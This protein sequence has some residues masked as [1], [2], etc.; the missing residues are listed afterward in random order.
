MRELR[1][2]REKLF[3]RLGVDHVVVRTDENF[4][5]PIR[6]LFARRAKRMRR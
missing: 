3:H 5:T 4:V 2:S 1:R 6:N